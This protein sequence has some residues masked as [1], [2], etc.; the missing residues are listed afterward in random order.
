MKKIVRLIGFNAILTV[1][2]L[3][4]VTLVSAALMDLNR[5][6]IYPLR[7]KDKALNEKGIL[8]RD[9]LKIDG[10]TY[11]NKE[12]TLSIFADFRKTQTRY[13]PFEGYRREPVS[14][15]T[16]TVSQDG[17]RQ[18]QSNENN[19]PD[20][21]RI[22]FFGG[23]T[24]WGTGVSDDQTIPAYV[25]QLSTDYTTT[26]FGEAGFT[27]RNSLAA[28]I[29]VLGA[30]EK[31][32][33]VIFYDGV[34]DSHYFCREEHQFS[35]HMYE[36]VVNKSLDADRKR[37]RSEMIKT[38]T[39]STLTLTKKIIGKAKAET[40][41]K[42]NYCETRPEHAAKVADNLIQ[43]WEIARAIALSQGAEFYAVLQPT[44]WQGE[45]NVSYLKEVGLMS[46][47]NAGESNVYRAL[48]EKLAAKRYPWIHDLSQSM[49]S[50]TPYFIDLC[51]LNAAGNK[52][53]SLQ[54]LE[55]LSR[56]TNSAALAPQHETPPATQ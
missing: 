40:T 5:F 32:D 23:S 48:R 54:L 16:T 19:G 21:K 44:P 12:E 47:T 2:L 42:E 10:P 4:V 1:G 11:V 53:I 26:N 25:D 27:S 56:R 6:V 14:L 50:E 3:L 13:R 46:E 7:H 18:H 30:K 52:R 37:I 36:D 33:I 49:V 20:A 28:Y 34:N 17:Y 55:F 39:G 29:N 45:P 41:G 35:T 51:H 38:L 43:N 8:K 9:Q 15:S 24:M 22:G 31:L